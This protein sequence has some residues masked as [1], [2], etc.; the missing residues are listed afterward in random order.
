MNCEDKESPVAGSNPV[1]V[2]AASVLGGLSPECSPMDCD[3]PGF[4]YLSLESQDN[5]TAKNGVADALAQPLV[6]QGHPL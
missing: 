1:R 3:I 5:R 4:C 2:K 6:Q